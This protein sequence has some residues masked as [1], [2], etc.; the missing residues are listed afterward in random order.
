MTH[1]LLN[2]INR[3]SNWQIALVIAVVGLAV[4]SSGLTN[5]FQ[6]DDQ[7]QIVENVPVHS[8]SHIKL[9]FEGG[10]FYNGQGTTPLS[11]IYYRPLMTTVFSLLY[12]LFGPHPFYFHLLQTLL[13]IASAYIFYL[14][15]RFSF[16]PLLSVT[17]ALVFLVHPLNSQVVFAIPSMQDALFFFFGILAIYLLIKYRSVKSLIAVAACLFLSLLSKESG[18]LFLVMAL[19]YL[20]W[21]D[22][23][24]LKPFLSIIALPLILYF[25]LK[26]HAVGLNG[27]PQNA[28][29]GKLNLAGRLL[30]APSIFIFFFTKLVLPIKLASGYYWTYSSFSLRHVLLP[31]VT[32]LTIFALFTYL[33]FIIRKRVDEPVLYTYWFFVIWAFLGLLLH[34]QIFPLDMTVAETWFYFAMAGFLG[35]IGVMIKAFEEQIN[36]KVLFFAMMCIIVIFGVRTAVRGHDWSNQLLLAQKDITASKEN[37]HAYDQVGGYLIQKYKF[38]D[39]EVYERSSI[40]IFPTFQNYSNL[41]ETLTGQGKYAEAKKAYTTSLGFGHYSKASENLAILT[42]VYGSPQE[43]RQFFLRA[44]NNFPHDPVLWTYLALFQAQ[45]GDSNGAKLAISNATKYGNVSDEIYN[46]IMNDQPFQYNLTGTPIRV[47][48]Q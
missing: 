16:T 43:N 30:T 46:R 42:L 35:A 34:L 2:K 7:S 10:T 47:N 3:L 11:G 39:A 12:T 19:L 29:I 45:H 1:T 22:R 14:L 40:D 18:F 26:I 24:R 4:F 36:L 23:K 21:F 8:I 17:L 37:Y 33:G 5:T 6:G 44:L 32:G 31:L 27:H 41:G 13:F 25:S 28:P 48:I 9:F 38:N 15:L 20:F